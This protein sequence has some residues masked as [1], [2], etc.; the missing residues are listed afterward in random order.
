[1]SPRVPEQIAVLGA[2]S[3]GTAVALALAHQGHD[4]L[5]WARDLE[6]VKRMEKTHSNE[7]YLPDIRFPDNLKVTHSLA[8]TQDYSNLL[9]AVPSHAFLNLLKQY[10]RLP[11]QGIA[12]LTKGIE[13]ESHRLFSDLIV[14]Q[15]G[16]TAMAMISG[17][18]FAKEVAAQKPTALMVASNHKQWA[19]HWQHLLHSN[20]TRVYI[21]EDLVG[22]QLCG[23]IKNVLA[24]A[25]GISDGLD[26]GANS[27]AALITRG[28]AEMQSLGM[29]MGGQ[30]S[31]FYGLAGLGDLVLTCT[32][33]QSRNRRFGLLIGKNYTKEQA[34]S[35]IKQVV[36][37]LHNASQVA[38]LARTFQIEM[39]IT[40]AVEKI[41]QGF[42]TPEHA[43]H[44]LL[45]RPLPT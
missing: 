21:S 30:V 1:M 39:P 42:L 4:V 41:I 17:P 32:D 29:A 12:W 13:P 7:K 8:K 2:G 44:Q 10:P 37:G 40:S 24:I 45:T 15:F 16:P 18:S 28:I 27:R 5:L 11:K 19:M 26:Y 36:E 9:I 20:V 23:A 34:C 3:W 38:S 14:E 25:C 31:T 35:E 22:V 6:H 33:N 43:A